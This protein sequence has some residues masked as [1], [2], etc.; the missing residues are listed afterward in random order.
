MNPI[1]STSKERSPELLTSLKAQGAIIPQS[2]IE[3]ERAVL[4]ALLL[5][6]GQLA[7]VAMILQPED[8]YD[9]KN[10][11]IYS[12][13]LSM[14]DNHR[15]IDLLT[16]SQT[17]QIAGK[18]DFLPY[19]AGLTQAIGSATHVIHHSRII[20]Q[21][22]IAR[23]LLSA[24]LEIIS[25]ANDETLDVADVLT[26]ASTLVD[27]IAEM[28]IGGK[29]GRHI[30]QL[31]GEALKECEK[32]C[33]AYTNGQPTGVTTGLHDL[34]RL[35]G[36][37]QSSQLIILAARP[38][39]GKT[40]LMLH[41]AKSAAIQG[42]PVC[43]YSLEM[44]DVSLA[45]RLLL[46][47]CS[48]DVDNFRSGRLTS[49]DWQ[50]LE[51]AASR[52]EKLP[53][54]VDDKASVTMRYIKSHSAIMAKKGKCG[55][56]M[57]DYLQLAD[58]STGERGRSREQEVTATSA[59]AKGIAKELNVPFVMLSQ[60]NRGV[61]GRADKKPVLSDLRE[62]GSIEQD[63]DIV[64]FIY[65]PA[66][67]GTQTIPTRTKGDISSEGVGVLSIAKQRDGATGDVVFRH[68]PSMTKIYDFE[69]EQHSTSTGEA[70]ATP[71]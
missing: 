33:T 49:T 44:S 29:G 37:W 10:E 66:Y 57:C 48:I 36:G 5:E 67:Y 4:G 8:F 39:M 70:P 19:L 54:Y 62:S 65:R 56:I 13:L 24:G 35:T 55:L 1:Q 41:L 51:K 12:A 18:K 17:P 69:P 53:I 6:A 20:K 7:D 45:N 2:A 61:E 50:E 3:L 21:K 71:F 16:V 31:A 9:P 63:A 46:S 11:I 38:A 22:S 47:E 59:K 52:L 28:A 68:N 15:K 34:D 60:L 43:I 64:A 14:A 27:K 32:R 23:G 30:R 58:M 42:V 26:N 40:A 25:Q